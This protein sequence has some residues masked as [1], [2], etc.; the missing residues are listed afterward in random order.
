VSR[1]RQGR[2]IDCDNHDLLNEDDLCFLCASEFEDRRWTR[3]ADEHEGEV[4]E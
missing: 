1:D 3:V 2:C 4:T